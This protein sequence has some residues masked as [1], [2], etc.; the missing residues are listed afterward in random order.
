MIALVPKL[1]V[2]FP[3]DDIRLSASCEIRTQDYYIELT[4]SK[5]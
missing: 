3:Q 5:H 1:V 2:F 4:K